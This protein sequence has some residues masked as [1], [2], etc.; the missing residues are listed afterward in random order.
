MV[1]FGLL[2]CTLFRPSRPL[3]L[4]HP[5][6]LVDHVEDF[7]N[8]AIV[9][10]ISIKTIMCS[11]RKEDMYSQ[12]VRGYSNNQPKHPIKHT[13]ESNQPLP[14]QFLK[15]TTT[16]TPNS[17]SNSITLNKLKIHRL[18]YSPFLQI[19]ILIPAILAPPSFSLHNSLCRFRHICP[20]LPSI[21]R[22][23][24]RLDMVRRVHSYILLCE[25]HPVL[26]GRL[27]PSVCVGSTRVS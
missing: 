13:T 7:D 17:N 4:F 3:L 12:D 2:G 26:A 25:R 21:I 18:L 14:R 22:F 1:N 20:H 24:G 11:E 8:I 19:P 27:P 16:P 15:K 6:L 23:N 9:I 10:K 5:L